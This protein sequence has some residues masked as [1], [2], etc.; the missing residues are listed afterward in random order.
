M[1]LNSAPPVLPCD[2]VPDAGRRSGRRR[3]PDRGLAVDL[4]TSTVRIASA[5]QLLVEEPSVIAR[6]RRRAVV[7][8]GT[9]ARAMLGR[10]PSDVEV[11][12]PIVDA[13][14]ADVESADHLLRTLLTRRG[15]AH[16]WAHEVVVAVPVLTTDLQRRTVLRCVQRVLP[17]AQLIPLEAPLAAAIG[18][19]LPVQDPFGT[20]VVDI[21][22]GATE[23]AVLSLGEM[24]TSHIAPVG[25]AAAEA[26][27]V[28]HLLVRYDLQLGRHSAERLIRLSSQPQCR[29]V[30]ARGSDRA[31]GLP[32]TLRFLS[33]EIRDVLAPIVDAIAEVARAALDAAPDALAADVMHGPITLTGGGSQ[34]HELPERIAELTGIDVTVREA[35]DRA[36]IDGARRCLTWSQHARSAR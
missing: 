33:S 18:A 10:N 9:D 6:S 31:T 22:R 5:G 32:R 26:A 29:S 23:A 27:V 30:V 28:T 14:I 21:G 34:L 1:F 16:G 7:A 13:L 3:R 17:R 11:V 4:G 24:V 20:M 8:A 25:G 2:P 35:P 19:G 12:E 15:L 36:V